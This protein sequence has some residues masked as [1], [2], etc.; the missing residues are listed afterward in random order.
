MHSK[1]YDNMIL[2]CSLLCLYS[3]LLLL[4]IIYY[5]IVFFPQSGHKHDVHFYH[6]TIETP[7]ETH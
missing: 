3:K 4:N 6:D 7:I 5:L 1:Y 2:I